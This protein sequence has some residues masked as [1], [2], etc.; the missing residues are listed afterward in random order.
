MGKLKN[1]FTNL[2][3]FYREQN[4]PAK[5]ALL[6][7]LLSCIAGLV[8]TVWAF[9]QR[10]AS[11]DEIYSLVCT[12]P[13][14]KFA[15][16]MRDCIMTDANPP[17]YLWFLFGLNKIFFID[18][19]I[20]PRVPSLIS[21]FLALIAAWS[22]FPK[23]Y[24][25]WA[26][27]IF[28][29]LLLCSTHFLLFMIG[30][31]SYSPSILFAVLITF[32][33][34]NIFDCISDGKTISLKR[35]ILFNFY[36]L[37][38]CFLHYY[39]ALLYGLLGLFIIIAAIRK[40]NT[41]WRSFTCGFILVLTLYCAWL[42]PSYLSLSKIGLLSGGW[43]IKTAPWVSSTEFFN[44][45][46]GADFVQYIFFALLVLSL[47]KFKISEDNRT[48]VLLPLTLFCAAYFIMYALSYKVNMMQGR[49]F[50]VFL[51]AVYLC[52][53]IILAQFFKRGKLNIL[54]FIVFLATAF[55]GNI[56]FV[57]K[58]Y[59]TPSEIKT[60][61]L[62][63]SAHYAGR[64]VLLASNYLFNDSIV[65]PLFSY[66]FNNAEQK[67]PQ[68]TN[69]INKQGAQKQALLDTDGAIIYI[70]GCTESGLER[71]QKQLP[72]TL[73]Y[74][75]YKYFYCILKPQPAVN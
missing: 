49:Y 1:A 30:A 50:I 10:G 17:L 18:S 52:I 66:Y 19:D 70:P 45:A 56:L 41:T 5:L 8:F 29:T 27:V 31:R 55:C 32:L 25:H 15:A 40:N 43:W 14:V 3:L 2:K 74:R 57:K 53:S 34:L 68:F 48:A 59:N 61:S 4:R 11:H 12:L 42:L 6:A 26:R 72:S 71:I 44:I 28:I 20:W 9:L 60:F 46:F 37:A 7:C 69:I 21:W 63:Y 39:G 38:L 65:E 47:I 54:L 24:G 22:L 58:N 13:T 67:P 16:L 62:Y 51:P 33:S 36:G 75:D 73:L 23:K 35:I 64:P